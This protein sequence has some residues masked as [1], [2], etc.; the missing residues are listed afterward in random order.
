MKNIFLTL[1]C[2]VTLLGI[3]ACSNDDAQIDPLANL[4]A[5]TQFGAN[6]FGCV[7]NGEVFY[8]RDERPGNFQP[9]LGKGVLFWGS[10]GGGGLL[11]NEIDVKNY[12]T[13]KPV[14]RMLIHLQHLDQ[15]GTGEYIWES[16]N[17][18]R[19]IDGYMNNYLY[20]QVYD[21]DSQA[22]KYYGSYENSGKVIV[23]RY[24]FTNRIVSGTFSGTLR[25]KNGTDLLEIQQGRF[26]FHWASLDEASF[27]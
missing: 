17:F 11:Y 18:E 1:L 19:D 10:S 23:T 26:D 12:V 8:P 22:W 6:T 13:A 20:C 9:T 4:P 2:V 16:T 5:E 14:S 15:T 7:V 27:P 21:K 25:L 3:S 24:D